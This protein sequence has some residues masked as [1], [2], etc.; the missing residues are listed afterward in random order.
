MSLMSLVPASQFAQLV[1][2][3]QH[4]STEHIAS[5]AQHARCAKVILSGGT[6][7]KKISNAGEIR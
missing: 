1:M 6:P 3:I 5:L 7:P 4:V 2:E